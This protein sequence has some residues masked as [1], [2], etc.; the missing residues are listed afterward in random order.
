LISLIGVVALT[1]F[2]YFALNNSNK[3]NHN[4]TSAR[5]QTEFVRSN[6]A[7]PVAPTIFNSDFN[8]TPPPSYSQVVSIQSPNAKIKYPHK[9]KQEK[10]RAQIVYPATRINNMVVVSTNV[11]TH[12]GFT[13]LIGATLI[14]TNHHSTDSNFFA[15]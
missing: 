2:C 5:N 11:P 1:A 15:V 12:S 7:Y 13:P 6:R 3:Q 14:A 8:D 9:N 10:T 4:R